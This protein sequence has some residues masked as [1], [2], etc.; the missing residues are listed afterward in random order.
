MKDQ[1]TKNRFVEPRAN[2]W[3]SDRIAKELETSKQTLINWSKELALEIAN[4]RA[5]ELEALLEKYY[6]VKEKRIE[7]FGDKLKAVLAELDKRDLKDLST[8]KLYDI[9]LKCYGTLQRKA[10]KPVFQEETD[11]LEA[12]FRNTLRSVNSW[13]AWNQNWTILTAEKLVS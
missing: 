13:K 12:S 4:L 5:M 1:E 7:V 9:M 2:G 10:V 8:E 11:A 3:S 6:L